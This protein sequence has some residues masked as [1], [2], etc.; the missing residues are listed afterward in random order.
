MTLEAKVFSLVLPTAL[1]LLGLASFVLTD[2]YI[3]KNQ[4][5]V[6]LITLALT[7]MMIIADVMD[8]YV[9][10]VQPVRMIRLLACTFGFIL[11]PVLIMMFHFFVGGSRRYV[12]AWCLVGV[13]TLIYVI[14]IFKP[15]AFRITIYKEVYTIYSR[16]ELGYTCHI[17]SAVLLL[18]LICLTFRVYR[19]RKK[20]TVVP[21]ACV[22]IISGAAVLGSLFD[23]DMLPPVAY[24]TI[25][26]VI[27]CIFIYIWFHRQIVEKYEEDLLAQ[28]RVKIMVSQIQPHFLYNTLATIKALCRTEPEKAATVTEKF[29]AYLRD[30][31]DSLNSDDLIP[32]KAEM[33]HTRVYADIEM[34]RFE[35]IRVEYDVEDTGFLLPALTI[36]P[37]V[38]NAIRHGVRIREEGIVRVSTRLSNGCHEIVISDN[39]CGFNAEGENTGDGNHIGIHNVRERIEKMCGGTMTIESEIDKGTTVTIRIPETEK[40]S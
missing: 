13:N 39:G 33:D 19:S 21:V 37:M 35:N 32:L 28:Q 6:M 14:N 4:K 16:T 22:V 7:A 17:I 9:I 27:S 29:G 34:V 23:Q 25:A 36:Q 11:R 12:P 10:N 31:L 26:T 2:R 3:Q 8:Y 5:R 15:I 38:E 30:N 40:K 1:I 24:L 18:N 20:Y